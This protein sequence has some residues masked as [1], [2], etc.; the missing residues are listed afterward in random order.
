MNILQVNDLRA[1][2]GDVEVLHSVSFNIA[3]GEILAVLGS[4]G[5]G[6]TTLNNNLSGIYTPK[7]GSIKFKERETAGSSSADIVRMG[8]IHVPE[9]RR[10]FGN[11]SVLENLKLGSYRRA[12]KRQA[13]NLEHVMDVFP[14]LAER[15]HQS[16]GT[17]SGGEQQML[18]IGRGLM[19]EPEL[20]ILDEPSLGLSPLLIE[21]M[22]I[23]IQRLHREGL[24]ILLVEQNIVQSMEIATRVLILEQGSITLQGSPAELLKKPELRSAYL[25]L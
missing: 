5:A 14:R 24:S 22:F 1:G 6:K 11:L 7:A 25:G 15:A 9:G 13:Q 17:L 10:V 12:G 4:N 18:A 21:E 3:Q 16:A 8:L 2:Y 19:G 23:L 20:L